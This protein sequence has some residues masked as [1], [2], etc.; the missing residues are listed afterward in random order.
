MFNKNKIV[1]DKRKSIIDYEFTLLQQKKP[2]LLLRV[3]SAFFIEQLNINL[4][5][6][7]QFFQGFQWINK[8]SRRVPFSRLEPC[9]HFQ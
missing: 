2:I 3:E 5:E 9:Q 7:L 8:G 4:A 6:V 1:I